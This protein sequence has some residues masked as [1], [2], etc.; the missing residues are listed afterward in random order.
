MNTTSND[1]TDPLL[2]SRDF[3]FGS[4]LCFVAFAGTVGNLLV[5][6]VIFRHRS[7]LK[8]NHY[9]VV[10]HLA[11]C[12]FFTLVLST[13][14]IYNAFTGSSVINSPVLCKLWY[15]T[16]T[17]F[18]IAAILFM[19][20]ISILRFQA[21]SKPLRPAISRWKVKVMTMLAYIFATICVLPYSL[22]LEFNATSGCVEKWPAEQLNIC[23]TLFLAAIQ[24]FIP[25]VLLSVAYCK[26][27]VELV[28]QNKERKLLFAS[29]AVSNEQNLS[30]YQ[31]FKQ[32]RN[33]RT[34]LVSL[35]IVVCF[36]VAY[37]PN[38]IIFILV[39]CRVID[40]PS[41]YKWFVILCFF[42][43]SAANPFIYG[44][45]D[46]KLFSSFIKRLR[47]KKMERPVPV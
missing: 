15:P 46:R 32:H 45:L 22:V 11:I 8:N 13:A 19:I 29:A 12:D 27:C 7:L 44:T 9:Y 5:I 37:L 28:R 4:M 41:Y 1:G 10:F 14:D 26:I 47:R 43:V 31:R 30:W 40:I 42:G 24:Y 23:Y 16:Y 36:A 3:V 17:A 21:V 39:V 18:Y 6:L 2:V 35:I 25:V 38:Q 33:A 20:I 34:F